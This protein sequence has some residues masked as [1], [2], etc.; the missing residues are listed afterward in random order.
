MARLVLPSR[1]ELKSPEGSL[2][3]APLER[4]SFTTHLACPV[5]QRCQGAELRDIVCLATF[6]AVAH[7]P[8]LLQDP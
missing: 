2:S 5:D 7:Q 4:V 3:E 1:L 8:S 6:V